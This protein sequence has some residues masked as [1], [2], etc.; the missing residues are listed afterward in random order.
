M[1]FTRIQAIVTALLLLAA[2]GN[3]NSFQTD[4]SITEVDGNTISSFHF[5]AE[6]WGLEAADRQT[7]FELAL[8]PED[9]DSVITLP[10]E[11]TVRGEQ[12]ECRMTLEPAKKT[13]SDGNYTLYL[14]STSGI[15]AAHP[16]LVS[17]RSHLV[18]KASVKVNHY[19]PMSGTG[20]ASDPFMIRSQSDF[21]NL[22]VALDDESGV[23]GKGLFYRQDADV[24]LPPQSSMT[25]GR[26]YFST[27][28]AGN[29]DGG[30]YKLTGLSYIG[31]SDPDKDSNV[32]VFSKLLPGAVVKN[33]TVE[34]VSIIKAMYCG[35]LAGSSSGNV[36]ILNVKASG[37]I[38]QGGKYIGGLVGYA[39]DTLT[40]D[41]FD[42][43]MTLSGTS[44]VGGVVGNTS[45]A[46]LTVKNVTTQK[47]RFSL[48]ADNFC[49]GV[50]GHA[51][52]SVQISGVT[53]DHSVQSPDQ[54][55]KIINAQTGIAGGVFGSL[56]VNGSSRIEDVTILAP[57]YSPQNTGGIAG[58]TTSR[59]TLTLSGCRMSSIVGGKS[60]TGGIFGYL[61]NT[62]NGRLVVEGDGCAVMTDF[63]AG[64]I[65][66]TDYTGGFCGYY[67]GTAPELKSK[68][69]LAMN[70]KGDGSF[71]GGVFGYID[72]KSESFPL[73]KINVEDFDMA[74]AT[75][76]VSGGDYVGGFIGKA[77]SYDIYAYPSGRSLLDS[78]GKATPYD[79]DK[80]TPHYKG[81]V[82][83]N[84][85][86]GGIAGCSERGNLEN[87]CVSGSV[88]GRNHV[89]GIVGEYALAYSPYGIIGCVTT[90]KATVEGSGDYCGGIAGS[91][92]TQYNSGYTPGCVNNCLN[93][94]STKGKD[95]TG[96]IAGRVAYNEC[97]LKLSWS[98]NTGQVTGTGST[99]GIVGAADGG[100]HKFIIENCAN[101]GSIASQAHGGQGLG[102][103]IGC[104][105]SQRIN[106]VSCAN[107][108]VIS[109]S[110]AAAGIGGVA[111]HLGHD[112]GGVTQGENLYL[113][114]C[115]NSGEVKCSDSNTNIGGLLGYQEEGTS[116]HHDDYCV[117]D[118]YND[119]PLTS[120]QKSDNGGL[121][122][123]VSHYS[124]I[125]RC[126]NYGKVSHGNACIG[127]RQS[128]AIVYHDYLYYLDGTGK[129]WYSTGKISQSDLSDKSKYHTFDFDNIWIIADGR[130]ELRHC[131]WQDITSF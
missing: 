88:T 98:V 61:S 45:S 119:G 7:L 95:Y 38:S 77:K 36:T 62:G 123:K 91:V 11:V 2:C 63:N 120:D 12:A 105:Y 117:R 129:D 78:S 72:A 40:V 122:G 94:A 128:S 71:T 70:V 69:T 56:D 96:G 109:G 112:P 22:I 15:R 80:E 35:A 16:L 13:I 49:G 68:V 24:E 106:V 9:T 74:S 10:A 30:G 97:E 82:Q 44:M 73:P 39:T 8:V 65:N 66:G 125:L 21:M 57:I 75:M 26:G 76:R 48:N 52:G 130:A 29:Y 51:E 50:A 127:T 113:A 114:F 46:L 99:G 34:G 102:G 131:P 58:Q 3:E 47:H 104:T 43:E 92:A 54:D 42:L 67:E 79:P 28:F 23:H 111:G 84:D 19:K 85:Y 108:G 60:S 101:Y 124:Y 115:M 55:V 37:T 87:L 33:V 27:P 118:S 41:G 126:M 110:G 6:E 89:G 93:S 25:G 31:A 32:G 100:S 1:K 81:V 83:G 116:S 53:L 4:P 18:E 107:H 20:T 17:L 90:T 14:F 5:N 86:V 121:V 64:E 59:E 103:I